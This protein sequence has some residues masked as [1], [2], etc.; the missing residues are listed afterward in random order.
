MKVFRKF[1]LVLLLC[2]YGILLKAQSSWEY[3][4]QISKILDSM[5]LEEKVSLC[6][7][8]SGGPNGL[9]GG[10]TLTYTSLKVDGW[11]S[12]S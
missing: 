4:A 3:S 6:A 10:S 11:A 2:C 5:T 7:G 12:W 1:L 8:R 9:N